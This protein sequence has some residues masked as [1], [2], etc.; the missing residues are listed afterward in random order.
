MTSQ[1]VA[2]DGNDV[3]Y[4][5]ARLSGYLDATSFDIQSPSS[6]E[7]TELEMSIAVQ[8]FC[9]TPMPAFCSCPHIVLVVIKYVTSWL[10]TVTSRNRYMSVRGPIIYTYKNTEFWAMWDCENQSIRLWGVLDTCLSTIKILC[11]CLSYSCFVRCPRL[12][13]VS[14]VCNRFNSQEKHSL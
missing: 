5:F 7:N 1:S 10:H 11:F 2:R 6:K 9:D 13:M 14:N 12:R 8:L 3:T 4:F